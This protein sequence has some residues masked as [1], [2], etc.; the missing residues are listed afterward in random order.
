M[1]NFTKKKIK[2]KYIIIF[3]DLLTLTQNPIKFKNILPEIEKLIKILI[4]NNNTIILPSYNLNFPKVKK[5]GH[6]TKFITT[7]YLIK[8]LLTKF[9][10]KR[11]NRPMYNYAVIGPNSEKILKLKQSTAWGND[12][13][14]SFLSTNKKTIGLGVNTSL[15]TFTW[16]AIHCCEEYL[17][18]PYRY[19][20]TFYGKNTTTKK[21]VKEKMYVRYLNKDNVDLKQK[22]ILKNL[23]IKKKLITKNGKSIK[24]NLINL[25]D[26]YIDNLKHIKKILKLKND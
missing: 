4:S 16:V 23:I 21:K 15:L 7:G 14:I 24:Y 6:D 20:K 17:K 5:T 10:F 2:S 22:I 9:S 26:Y 3:A 8:F 12:S 25:N 18:V 1:L 11:T 19:Y 13:V